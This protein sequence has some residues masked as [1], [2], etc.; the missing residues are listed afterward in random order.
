MERVQG[1]KP[2][3]R[4]AGIQGVFNYG[5][6]NVEL[7]IRNPQSEFLRTLESSNPSHMGGRKGEITK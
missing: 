5:M 2:A 3:C 1:I 7:K 4:Q 6:R